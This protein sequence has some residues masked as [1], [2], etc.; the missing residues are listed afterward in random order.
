MMNNFLT[1]SEAGL[2]DADE[3]PYKDGLLYS[4]TMYTDKM[5]GIIKTCESNNC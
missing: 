3:F 5:K 2:I 4:D 1:L